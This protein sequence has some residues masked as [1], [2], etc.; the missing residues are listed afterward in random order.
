MKKALR[1]GERID[2][3]Y[4]VQNTEGEWRW[5]RSRGLPRM[6][7]NGEI[8]RWYGSLED[9]HE[10][11]CAES[12]ARKTEDTMRALLR[13]VPVEIM[14]EEGKERA[15]RMEAELHAELDETLH[16]LSA[17]SDIKR[18]QDF[19]QVAR[20]QNQK[21]HTQNLATL[22]AKIEDHVFQD[23]AVK[24]AVPA[25]GSDLLA[26]NKRPPSRVPRRP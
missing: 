5:M 16:D 26:E 4:R 8:Q 10:K 3:E 12:E 17:Q 22:A 15:V 20:N 19:Q 13:V 11:K 6:G 24:L 9:I 21:D 7:T 23:S 1:T 14:I 25:S 2:M 18:H